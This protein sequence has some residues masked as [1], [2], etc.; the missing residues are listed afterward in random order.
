MKNWNSHISGGIMDLT[1]QRPNGKCRE[2]VKA[3]NIKQVMVRKFSPWKLADSSNQRFFVFLEIIIEN[4][5]T[6]ALH[7]PPTTTFSS[8]AI[9]SCYTLYHY[10]DT[11]LLSP[12]LQ[13]AEGENLWELE[14]QPGWPHRQGDESATTYDLM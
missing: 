2:F 12:E 3:V 10:R 9:D 6:I 8:V 11:L 5:T 7:L 14:V 13:K 1:H 4:F